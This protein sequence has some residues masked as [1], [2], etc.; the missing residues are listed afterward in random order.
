L[1]K[2]KG[3]NG[4]GSDFDEEIDQEEIPADFYFFNKATS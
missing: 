3:E 1:K 4:E 2:D